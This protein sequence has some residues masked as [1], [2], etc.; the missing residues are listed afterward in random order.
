MTE[1][2]TRGLLKTLAVMRA[3][4]LQIVIGGGWAPFLY[5]RYLSK[6]RHLIVTAAPMQYVHILLSGSRQS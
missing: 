5:Y 4:H 3:Y 6:N 1:D 2:F